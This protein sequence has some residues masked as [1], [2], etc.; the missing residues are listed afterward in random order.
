M[1][2]RCFKYHFACIGVD[3]RLAYVFEEEADFRP[4]NGTFGIGVDE[5]EEGLASTTSG[6]V[7]VPALLLKFCDEGG[8]FTS[9]RIR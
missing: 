6:D 1:I 5:L 3:V 4:C 2:V 8:D 9:V 7:S